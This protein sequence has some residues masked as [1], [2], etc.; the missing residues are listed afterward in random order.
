MVYAAVLI[1][2]LWLTGCFQG[3]PSEKPPIHINP[4][5]DSQPRYNPQAE[6]AFFVDGATMRQPVP[7]TVARGEL[8]A[9]DAFYRGISAAGDTIRRNPLPVTMQVLQ[10]GQ[11]RY[12]I[13]CA[14]C[15]GAVGDGKGI[16]VQRGYLPP[17]TFHSDLLRSY[18]DGHIY[19]VISNGIRN[20]PAYK[21]QIPVNDRWAI[22]AYF[23]ALQ[24]SQNASLNDIPEE[25]RAEYE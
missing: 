10:R 14:P 4:N 18:P 19:N 12:D 6:S 24:R 2:S 11:E 13:F 1:S 15:H 22:V 5:M 9:D 23:R 7:G 25:K 20:M 16:V 3:M 21:H 8:R 17:P